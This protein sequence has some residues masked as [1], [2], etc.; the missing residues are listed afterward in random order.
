MN[1]DDDPQPVYAA[2]GGRA[3]RNQM[4]KAMTNQYGFGRLPES[5]H[6]KT[7][8]Y[9]RRW[10]ATTITSLYSILASGLTGSLTGAGK[11]T[12]SHT[13]MVG[14]VY[15]HRPAEWKTALFYTCYRPAFD[16]GHL[17]GVLL[18]HAMRHTGSDWTPRLRNARTTRGAAV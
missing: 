8:G 6:A 16:D 14:A 3:Q 11:A 7:H 2:T 15:T 18:E 17:W 9:S 4:L 5:T 10:H 1:S 13:G 12:E